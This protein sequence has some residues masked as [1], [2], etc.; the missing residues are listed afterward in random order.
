[1]L[2]QE[3]TLKLHANMEILKTGQ[4]GILEKWVTFIETTLMF[5]NWPQRK[6]GQ[7]IQPWWLGGRAVV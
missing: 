4:L 1:M 3:S 5:L 2:L 7:S 6:I